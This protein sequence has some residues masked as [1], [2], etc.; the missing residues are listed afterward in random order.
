M[1]LG[2]G[3]CLCNWPSWVAKTLMFDNTHKLFNQ[4]FVTHLLMMVDYVRELIVKKFC[5][6]SEYL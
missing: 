2:N 4:I 1:D 5:E 3:S 6:Y